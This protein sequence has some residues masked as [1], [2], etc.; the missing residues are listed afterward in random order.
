[1]LG[2]ELLKP[3]FNRTNLTHVTLHYRFRVSPYNPL[4]RSSG[5][6][7]AA[8][9]LATPDSDEFSQHEEPDAERRLM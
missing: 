2:P 8:E 5:S 6:R 7:S 9:N 1:M 3:D 4:T